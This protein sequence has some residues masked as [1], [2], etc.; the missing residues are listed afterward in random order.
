MCM[1]ILELYAS[2]IVILVPEYCMKPNGGRGA[3]KLA[4]YSRTLGTGGGGIIVGEGGGGHNPP[5]YNRR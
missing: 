5:P 3:G 2:G 4:S 1:L